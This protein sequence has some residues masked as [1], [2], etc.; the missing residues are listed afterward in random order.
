MLI[1]LYVSMLPHS[2][3]MKYVSSRLPHWPFDGISRSDV[4][5]T[6]LGNSSKYLKISLNICCIRFAYLPKWQCLPFCLS[7]HKKICRKFVIKSICCRHKVVWDFYYLKKAPTTH[8]ILNLKI[9]NYSNRWC[10]FSVFSF[11]KFIHSE[12]C[13]A[14]QSLV[15]SVSIGMYTLQAMIWFSMDIVTFTSLPFDGLRLLGWVNYSFFGFCLS[16]FFLD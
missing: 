15:H 1:V 6:N 12:W 5:H 11:N 2:I 10:G 7:P 4:I 13:D 3:Q 8:I 14:V 9:R 16:I